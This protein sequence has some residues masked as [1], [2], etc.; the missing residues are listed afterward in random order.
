MD[1]R[2]SCHRNVYVYAF[3]FKGAVIYFTK[4]QEN[5]NKMSNTQRKLAKKIGKVGENCPGRS[6]S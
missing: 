1:A 5:K 4:R 2:I 3:L 6:M